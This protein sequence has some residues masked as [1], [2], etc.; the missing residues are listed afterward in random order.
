MNIFRMKTQHLLEDIIKIQENT[1]KNEK[2][3][4]DNILRRWLDQEDLI[5]DLKYMNRLLEWKYQKAL[6]DIQILDHYI[7]QKEIKKGK[8]GTKK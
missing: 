3:V 7:N 2:I 1:I 5:T 8:N 6:E 4:S